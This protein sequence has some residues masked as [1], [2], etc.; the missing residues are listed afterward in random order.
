MGAE[1]DLDDILAQMFGMH[2]MNGSPGRGPGPRKPRRGNDE[3]QSYTV[4]LEELYKGKTTKFASQKNVI[5]KV[6]K[7]SGGKEKAKPK[8]CSAC[9]GRGN[10]STTINFLAASDKKHQACSKVSSLWDQAW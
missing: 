4:T 8:E 2:G 3:E 10:Y 1:V 9:H 6:C 5:C 7:G